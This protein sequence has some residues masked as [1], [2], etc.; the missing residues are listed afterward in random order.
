MTALPN[1]IHLETEAFS[2]LHAYEVDNRPPIASDAATY[3]AVSGRLPAS[4]NNKIHTKPALRRIARPFLPISP[5]TNNNNKRFRNNNKLPAFN[6]SS[7]HVPLT[8]CT[9][10]DA[11]ESKENATCKSSVIRGVRGRGTQVERAAYLD[12][13]LMSKCLLATRCGS[14]SSGRAAIRSCAV[15]RGAAGI[16]LAWC[17]R[18]RST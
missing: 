8:S 11:H 7:A 4:H 16:W 17:F 3:S 2:H 12:A 10:D 9:H 13:H 1:P 15:G 6:S 5:P 18:R 14:L